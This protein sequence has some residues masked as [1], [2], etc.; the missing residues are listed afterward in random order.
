MDELAFLEN[1]ELYDDDDELDG[2]TLVEVEKPKRRKR[3]RNPEPA[4]VAS[5]LL[6]LGLAYAGWILFNKSKF[7]T[8]NFAP[9]KLAG[10]SRLQLRQANPQ[11]E[12]EQR[13]QAELDKAIE[14]MMEPSVITVDTEV[15]W[16]PVYGNTEKERVSF[17]EP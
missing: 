1:P 12:A 8:W 11:T 4:F 13:R 17:I 15:P 5:P 16:R 9:W 3:K 6:L 10:R 14:K 7:G 2:L